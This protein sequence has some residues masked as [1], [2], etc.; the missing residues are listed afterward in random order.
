[1]LTL[2]YIGY[3]LWGTG[4]SAGAAQHRLGRQLQREWSTP[5]VAEVATAQRSPMD[6]QPL[7][8]LTVPRLGSQYHEVVI[9]GV[10][11]A[12]LRMAPGHYPG[13]AMPGQLG[14]FAVAGHRTTYGAPF[15]D[16]NL[17]RPGDMIAVQVANTSYEYR[18]TAHEIV[19]PSDIAV[20]APTPDHP[21]AKPV[22][23]MLTLTTCH[24]KYSAKERLVVHAQLVDARRTHE[25][26][27]PA[28]PR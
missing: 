14:N 15:G 5:R 23:G 7:A 11:T 4:P 1:L 16:L 9:E 2:L 28:V 19:R 21:G 26:T 27:A 22:R 8:I 10:S 24:P 3:Q 12:D 25:A 13:S 20:I 6:S 17:L 18:V